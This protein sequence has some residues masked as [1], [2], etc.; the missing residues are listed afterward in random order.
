M[1]DSHP[2]ARKGDEGEPNGLLDRD[3][4]TGADRWV[5]QGSFGVNDLERE[6]KRG[7]QA[8]SVTRNASNFKGEVLTESVLN[9]WLV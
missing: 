4:D 9:G 3:V 6:V 2:A 5:G 8:V 1:F 7:H